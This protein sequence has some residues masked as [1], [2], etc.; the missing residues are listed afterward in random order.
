MVDRRDGDLLHA[1]CQPSPMQF[2]EISADVSSERIRNY[3]FLGCM[4]KWLCFG[5]KYLIPD[6][7]QHGFPHCGRYRRLL[8]T[9]QQVTADRIG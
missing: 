8:D 6:A 1:G 4:R 5:G 3:C 9:I 7:G 2:V